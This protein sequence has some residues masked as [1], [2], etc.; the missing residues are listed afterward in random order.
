MSLVDEEL[1]LNTSAA[2]DTRRRRQKRAN[3]NVIFDSDDKAV[4]ELFK[5]T[6]SDSVTDQLE[7]LKRQLDTGEKGK[8]QKNKDVNLDDLIAASV[9]TDLQKNNKNISKKAAP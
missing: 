9:D 5:D 7:S 1:L 8:G 3:Q 2:L 6:S 4:A